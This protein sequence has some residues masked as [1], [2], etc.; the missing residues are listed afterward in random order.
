MK[1]RRRILAD[2]GNPSLYAAAYELCRNACGML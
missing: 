2:I 1:L